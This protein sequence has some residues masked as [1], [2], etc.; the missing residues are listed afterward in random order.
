[1]DILKEAQGMEDVVHMEIGEPDLDPPPGV[2]EAVHKALRERKYFYTPSLG[3][4]AL[5][6]RIA[7]H[8]FDYYGVDVSPSRVV[9]TTGT[10]SALLVAYAVFV[11]GSDRVVLPDPSYPCYKNFAHLLDIEPLMVNVDAGTKYQVTVDH[12]EFLEGYRAVHISTPTNPTGTLYEE[13]NLRS[14]SNFCEERGLYLIC[15]EIYHGLVYDRRERTALE[16]SSK[17]VVINGFS[18]AF[19]MPGFRLGWIIMPDEDSV[20]KAELILQNLYISAPTLSQY[21]AIE[22]FDYLY[23]SKVRETYK[24]RRDMLLEELKDV[25]RVE[26]VPDGAF[27]LWMDISKYRIDSYQ[28]SMRLL[29]EARVAVTPGKDFGNNN[30]ERY[31]RISFAKDG[32]TLKEGARRIRDY[33]AM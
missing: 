32:G 22:A 33:L 16:F 10:S 7:K 26:L 28:L 31:I 14:I 29:R 20:R 5:R 19:C 4:W 15:D 11:D 3:L 2:I 17:A 23:L 24:N 21:A 8:Y 30:T 12:L 1:M 18:K 25:G 27:Y 13:E 9:V 6:E